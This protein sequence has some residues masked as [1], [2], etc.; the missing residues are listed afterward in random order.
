MTTAGKGDLPSGYIKDFGTT[1]RLKFLLNIHQSWNTGKVPD[2]WRETAIIIIR[3]EQ[4]GKT[5]KS[6]KKPV[7]L[8][9]CLSKGDG[10]YDGHKT[11]ETPERKAPA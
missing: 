2:I 7:S 6:S 8:L 3:K 5:G 10:Q 9:S 4:K 11:A 1:A